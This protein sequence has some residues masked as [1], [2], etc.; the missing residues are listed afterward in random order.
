MNTQK[1]KI[2]NRNRILKTINLTSLNI[3]TKTRVS[4]CSRIL[5]FEID[6]VKTAF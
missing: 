1:K 6:A 2:K 4:I 5:N 3:I